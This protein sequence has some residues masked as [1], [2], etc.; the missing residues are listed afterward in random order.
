MRHL[1]TAQY[2]WRL[3]NRRSKFEVKFV[4]FF[5]RENSFLHQEPRV[6]LKTFEKGK[7]TMCCIPVQLHPHLNHI[8]IQRFQTQT[9]CQSNIISI[10]IYLTIQR[11]E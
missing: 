10:K 7:W 2:F 4:I 1:M 11:Y 5:S 3:F 8:P 6:I 9:H